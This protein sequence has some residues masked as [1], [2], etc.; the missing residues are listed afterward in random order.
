MLSREG[1]ITIPKIDFHEPLKNQ[2]RYFIQCVEKDQ[3]PLLA[4][5]GKAAD[6]VRTL[7][8]IGESINRKGELV[9]L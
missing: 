5:A 2:V 7:E 4:D 3:P 6:V 8:A 1:N 9:K